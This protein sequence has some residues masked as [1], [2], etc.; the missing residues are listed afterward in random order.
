[1]PVLFRKGREREVSIDERSGRGRRGGKKFVSL[2]R[3]KDVARGG[4]ADHQSSEVGKEEGDVQ[5]GKKG[6]GSF[7]KPARQRKTIPE[8]KGKRG[9]ESTNIPF[10]EGGGRALYSSVGH[11]NPLSCSGEERKPS[12]KRGKKVK[13]H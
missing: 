9:E 4:A 12:F 6:G 8:K 2:R 1:M 13:Y 3:E 5:A 11:P 10:K 7:P